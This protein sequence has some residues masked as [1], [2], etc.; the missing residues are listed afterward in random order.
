MVPIRVKTNMMRSLE[1]VWLSCSRNIFL[2]QEQVQVNK[3]YKLIILAQATITTLEKKKQPPNPFLGSNLCS[4]RVYKVMNRDV[5]PPKNIKIF[6]R[7]AHVRSSL[8]LPAIIVIQTPKNI[9]VDARPKPISNFRPKLIG[10]SLLWGGSGRDCVQ[11]VSWEL[12][13]TLVESEPK[14][15]LN[16][17]R[18]RYRIASDL[19]HW[20]LRA[21]GTCLF[22]CARTIRIFK[23]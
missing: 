13:S 3:P 12:F 15:S 5:R 8:H 11:G 1:L 17:H 23:N 19:W 20:R 10:G 4:E 6:N 7:K 22:W 21:C 18:V 2:L 16:L 14:L 9:M